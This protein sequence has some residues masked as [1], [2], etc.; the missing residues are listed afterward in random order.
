M[1]WEKERKYEIA[2]DMIC[3]YLNIIIKNNR[4]VM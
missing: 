1:I 2:N 4:L 3:L